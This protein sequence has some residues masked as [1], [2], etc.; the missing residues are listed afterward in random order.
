MIAIQVLDRIEFIHSKYYIHRDIKPDNF[1]IGKEDPNIIYLVN[2]GLSKKYRSTKTKNHVR[3]S[4]TGRLTGTLR[5]ASSN[6]F[7]GS[8]QSR[9]DDLI[10]IGYMLIYFMKR[11]LPW[12]KIRDKNETDRYI[13][14]YKMKK[15]IKPEILC[16]GLP[17]EMVE[18]MKYV[19]HLGFEQ[20][21]NYKYLRNLFKSILKQLN[22]DV[23]G[24][25]FSWIKQSEIKNLKNPV[26][27]RKRK[28]SSRERL[29]KKISESLERQRVPSHDSLGRHNYERFPN[30]VN[31]N[32][33]PNH[34]IKMVRNYSKETFETN[35]PSDN[36]NLKSKNNSKTMFVNFDK[37]IGGQLL[38]AFEM[39]DNQTENIKS[40]NTVDK[41]NKTLN[42]MNLQKKNE[43]TNLT[44]KKEVGSDILKQLK[45]DNIN[46]SDK[47]KNEEKKIEDFNI[48]KPGNKVENKFIENNNILI[49]DKN[50]VKKISDEINEIKE[51][52]QN[53]LKNK[54]EYENSL[55]QNILTGDKIKNINNNNNQTNF[56]VDNNN[57]NLV[58]KNNDNNCKN[59][60][61]KQYNIMNKNPKKINMNNKK[62]NLENIN[63]IG[64]NNPYLN[65]KNLNNNFNIIKIKDDFSNQ[66]NSKINKDFSND[67]N[68][69]Y[70]NYTEPSDSLYEENKN[71]RKMHMI[72][73][74]RINKK[75]KNVFQKF[76]EINNNLNMNYNI[77][78]QGMN[79][80]G[81]INQINKQMKKNNNNLINRQREIQT[82]NNF[83]N[84][85]NNMNMQFN[86][87]QNRGRNLN[88][89][90]NNII[91][92]KKIQG[93]IKQQ[94]DR[95][96]NNNNYQNYYNI[97]SDNIPMDNISNNNINFIS[98]NNMQNMKQYPN[99]YGGNQQLRN[100]NINNGIR[101]FGYG[102]NYEDFNF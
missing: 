58:K 54:E 79:F 95:N 76:N 7:K 28:S 89:N 32:L 23:E 39:M 42:K 30:I 53:F 77:N 94:N 72:Q 83:Y 22:I 9:R 102:M 61:N 75:S 6:A 64:M 55:K 52:K 29:F 81:N 74:E 101:P 38:E 51:N 26:D 97:P 67:I 20:E 13:K 87:M 19:Q 43:F 86:N 99:S 27:L 1:L 65:N 35:N 93:K 91:K 98:N 85:M 36:S 69:N 33:N 37:T 73:T 60:M 18:Y 17:N 88:N 16:Q 68:S 4:N 21:P 34:N 96:I 24:C 50:R 80:E 44:E 47:K 70:K 2:F 8:E 78:N 46:F 45:L 48:N 57:S 25:L 66:I 71:M 59:K 62:I 5:Y 82:N 49:N 12:Q 100:N 90:N 92:V 56:N 14:I 84:H 41:H 3:F 40:S 63:Y 10:S 15:E 31:N 11:E